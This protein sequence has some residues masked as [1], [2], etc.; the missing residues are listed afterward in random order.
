MKNVV[1]LWAVAA[2]ASLASVAPTFTAQA[3]ATQ[4]RPEVSELAECYTGDKNL[5]VTIVRVGKRENKQALVE[6]VGLDHPW[7]RRI[8]KANVA[9]IAP[10]NSSLVKNEYI[11]KVNGRDWHL[12]RLEDNQLTL[13][14]REDGATG[15]SQEYHLAF[16]Q[17][18]SDDTKPEY[19]LTAYLKQ[20]SGGKSK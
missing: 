4:A 13:F 16:S 6:I 12:A 2:F 9:N 5:T 3:Q 14:L 11:I 18:V 10:A 20:E 19:L 7:N 17:G 8:F 1:K 15:R